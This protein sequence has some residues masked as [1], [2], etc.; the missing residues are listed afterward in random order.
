LLPHALHCEDEQ[1]RYAPTPEVG[2]GRM[3]SPRRDA[4]D[5]AGRFDVFRVR[6][7]L[8]SQLRSIGGTCIEPV[9][10]SERFDACVGT[11]SFLSRF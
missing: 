3:P 8:G 4:V 11:S 1:R 10:S 6:V 9:A 7:E 5:A 2:T